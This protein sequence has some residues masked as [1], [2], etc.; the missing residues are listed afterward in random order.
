MPI[1]HRID[2]STEASV[3][4]PGSLV[5]LSRSMICGKNPR[6]WLLLLHR[7]FV[8]QKAVFAKIA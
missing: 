3:S 7:G 4:L 6:Y 5:G 2:A 1:S 8:V